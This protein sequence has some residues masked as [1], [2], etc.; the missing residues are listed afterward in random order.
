MAAPLSED[1]KL[2]AEVRR[3]TLQKIKAL[4]LLPRVD[5]IDHDAQLHDKILE[6][7]AGTVLPRLT[8]VTGEDGEPIKVDNVKGLTTEQINELLKAKLNAGS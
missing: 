5:M 7:L 1:R 4:F 8:E 3:M 2:A 6:R